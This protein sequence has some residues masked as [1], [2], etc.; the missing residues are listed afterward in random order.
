MMIV[1]NQFVAKPGSASTLAA[2]LKKAAGVAK[3]KKARVLTDVSGDFNRVV[4]EYEVENLAGFEAT[5]DT[6]ATDEK[7]RAAM[8]GYTD[9]WVTGSREFMRVV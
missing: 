7:F 8:K 9:L 5:M 1:R 2:Q 6:Y 3:L 4:M